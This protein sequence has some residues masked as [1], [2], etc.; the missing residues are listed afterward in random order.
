[1]GGLRR[2]L[3]KLHLP[4]PSVDS[5]PQVGRL[6]APP[7]Y[8]S[9]AP[10]SVRNTDQTRA[11]NSAVSDFLLCSLQVEVGWGSG[12][13]LCGGDRDSGAHL[14]SVVSKVKV[15][16]FMLNDLQLALTVYCF[17]LAVGMKQGDRPYAM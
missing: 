5:R 16:G 9:Q 14:T 12:E 2:G 10:P 8:S 13:E 4:M 6:A 1:M 11:G 3:Q 17:L 7:T 15:K